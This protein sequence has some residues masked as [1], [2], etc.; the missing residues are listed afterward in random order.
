MS[1]PDIKILISCHKDILLPQSE[2]FLPIHVGAARAAAPLEGMQ[3]DNE[4]DNISERNF[5]FCELTGQYWAWKN[6]EA[7]YVGQCHY[8]RFF[9]FDGEQHPANDHK[10]M[11]YPA[12]SPAA[13]EMF[14]IDDTSRIEQ[15]VNAHDMIVPPTWNVKAAPTPCGPQATIADHMIS[16]GLF[17]LDDVETL[18]SIVRTKQPAYFDHLVSY[19]EGDQYRGYNCFIMKRALF[20]EL[21]EFEFDVLL[22]FDRLKDYSGLT[23]TK[24]RICGYLGEILF[25]VFVNAVIQRGDCSVQERPMVFFE[26][27]SK[28]LSIPAADHE[29]ACN[30]VWRW[31]DGPV[32]ALSVCLNSL[33]RSC[34]P[35]KRYNV[36]ILTQHDMPFARMLQGTD[37][38][39][40]NIKVSQVIWPAIRLPLDL[41]HVDETNLEHY[42]P[43]YLPW[44][45][46]H[47]QSRLLWFEGAV[48]LC[49]DPADILSSGAGAYSALCNLKL[50]RELNK[51]PRRSL[52][53]RYLTDAATSTYLGL[54]VC[55]VNLHAARNTLTPQKLATACS[56]AET[57]TREFGDIAG[58]AADSLVLTSLGAGALPFPMACPSLHTV[59]TTTWASAESVQAWKAADGIKTRCISFEM[60]GAPIPDI[61]YSHNY[62]FWQ[63]ARESKV[64]ENLVAP[65]PLPVAAGSGTDIVHRL[66]PTGTL[67]WRIVRKLYGM[68]RHA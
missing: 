61:E 48:Q 49:G 19:L 55:A 7:E 39:P 2:I 42:L 53:T 66:F 17:D 25:S 13:F 30:I 40:K 59:D 35:E 9:A 28:P 50:E 41:A 23:T 58:A 60:P 27:T 38:I 64:Y 37:Q 63:L 56:D 14:H 52:K 18:K 11:E 5:T 21:C 6:L 65:N 24:R 26:T 47:S 62:L 16:Y 31:N 45:F 10:Q 32:E 15:E 8:R 68:I 46:P 51:P 12:M 54:N 44:L 1:K 36:D 57:S 20:D 22:E 29:D 4:G 33:I 3:P 43:L 67:R 34:S